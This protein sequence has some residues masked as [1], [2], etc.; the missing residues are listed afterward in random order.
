M[1]TYIHKIYLSSKTIYSFKNI[2][3]IVRLIKNI[4]LNKS[5]RINEKSIL[6]DVTNI[7]NI[8]LTEMTRAF[9]AKPI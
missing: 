5:T 3:N 4:Y 6:V 2:A 7:L 8:L 9:L 1:H